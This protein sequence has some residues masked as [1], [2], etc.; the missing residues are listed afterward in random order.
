MA[1]KVESAK[2]YSDCSSMVI[3]RE[4][5][6]VDSNKLCRMPVGSIVLA[7]KVD[8]EWS[9]VKANDKTGYVMNQFL[10]YGEQ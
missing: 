5:M 2:V 10:I 4:K 7:K 1:V 6:A 9:F 3:L 8:N